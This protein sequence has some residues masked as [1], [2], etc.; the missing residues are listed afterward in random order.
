VTTPVVDHNPEC[1]G[2]DSSHV[3]DVDVGAAVFYQA[4]MSVS[5][6]ASHNR[7]AG[8]EVGVSV[9]DDDDAS[10]GSRSDGDETEALRTDFCFHFDHPATTTSHSPPPVVTADQTSYD[11]S[12]KTVSDVSVDDWV[13]EGE[14]QYRVC[15][16]ELGEFLEDISF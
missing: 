10:F 6:G 11:G 4:A 15:G 5:S 14:R 2:D 13:R 16:K 12:C 1:S 9:T 7:G 3:D 8:S